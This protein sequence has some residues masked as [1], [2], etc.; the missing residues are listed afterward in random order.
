M[1]EC[2]VAALLYCSTAV[3]AHL[4]TQP[5]FTEVPTLI[6]ALTSDLRDQ[7]HSMPESGLRTSFL[8]EGGEK[9]ED[10]G[11]FLSDGPP[12]RSV[13]RGLVAWKELGSFP[14]MEAWGMELEGV[15]QLLTLPVLDSLTPLVI[16]YV[17]S[18]DGTG[19]GRAAS[20]GHFVQQMGV[21]SLL[22][23]LGLRTTVGSLELAP[24]PRHV[25]A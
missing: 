4:T 9:A 7:L 2:T 16:D 13:A 5:T 10:E 19:T 18:L 11:P 25:D 21:R 23:L 12:L 20:D 22:A 24:P 15:E 17:S 14:Y 1:N 6:D 3:S 8:W